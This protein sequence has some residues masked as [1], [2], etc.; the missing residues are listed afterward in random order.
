MTSPLGSCPARKCDSADDLG[1][2]R[3]LRS[4][5][6]FVGQAVGDGSSADPPGVEVDHGGAQK[7]D[8]QIAAMCRTQGPPW[9]H[10]IWRT[11]G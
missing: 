8:A 4:V 3:A 1:F 6:I 5:R 10:E 11:S 9:L 7:F 2:V